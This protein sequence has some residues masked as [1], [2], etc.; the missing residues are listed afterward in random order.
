MYMTISSRCGNNG[1]FGVLKLASAINHT[2][3]GAGS[4]EPK[5]EKGI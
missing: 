2:K 5:W 3:A 1:F 4:C